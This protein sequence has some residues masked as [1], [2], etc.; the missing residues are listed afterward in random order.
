MTI[1]RAVQ[2]FA[3]TMILL[4]LGLAHFVSPAWLF[5]TLFIGLNLFQAGLTGF[6]PAVFIFRKL[7]F[8]EA[9]R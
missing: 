8:K 3:G 2:T 1:H 9:D 4:S 6:C 5:F 7:G